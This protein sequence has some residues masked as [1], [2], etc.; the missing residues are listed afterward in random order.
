MNFINELINNPMLVIYLLFANFS[1]TII[2][3]FVGIVCISKYKKLNLRYVKKKKKWINI[4]KTKKLI[5]SYE[6]YV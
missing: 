2:A 4:N 3:I 1:I 6:N 5:I